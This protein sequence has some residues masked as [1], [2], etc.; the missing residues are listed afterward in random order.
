MQKRDKPTWSIRL[1]IDGFSI[2][3]VRVDEKTAERIAKNFDLPWGSNAISRWPM[4]MNKIGHEVELEQEIM[5]KAL[6]PQMVIPDGQVVYILVGNQTDEEASKEDNTLITLD[7]AIKAVY[8]ETEGKP[9]MLWSLLC[10]GAGT[11]LPQ[12]SKVEDETPSD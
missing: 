2:I 8:E 5:S 3:T 7:Q 11:A 9:P 1:N 4:T 12:F 6:A 10:A